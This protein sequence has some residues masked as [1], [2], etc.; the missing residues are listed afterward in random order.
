MM[1]AANEENDAARRT[2]AN[3]CFTRAAPVGPSPRRSFRGELENRLRMKCFARPENG[4]GKIRM[5]RRIREMLRF[6]AKSVAQ[7]VRMTLFSDDGSIQ[8]IA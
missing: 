5:I 8:E 7:L 4:R 6:Q 1:R 3:A 2:D